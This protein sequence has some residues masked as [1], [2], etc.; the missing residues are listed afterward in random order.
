MSKT[1]QFTRP[2]LEA[3]LLKALVVQFIGN[4]CECSTCGHLLTKRQPSN[5]NCCGCT[6]ARAAIASA[7]RV[8]TPEMLKAMEQLDRMGPWR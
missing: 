1:R 2:E 6:D 8:N 4:G 5:E 3:A 7:K